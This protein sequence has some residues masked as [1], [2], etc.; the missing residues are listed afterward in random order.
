[1]IRKKGVNCC[2]FGPVGSIKVYPKQSKGFLSISNMESEKLDI[3]QHK[4]WGAAKKL[5]TLFI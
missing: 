2:F 3:A 5:F 1:M 4:I